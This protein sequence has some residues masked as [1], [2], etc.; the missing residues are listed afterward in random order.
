MTEKIRLRLGGIHAAKG[1]IKGALAQFDAVA[2]NP[3]SQLIGWANY[4]AGE[5]LIQNQQFGD[6]VKRLTIFRDNP[7]WQNVPGLSDRALVRLGYASSLAKGWDESRT[8]Y[9]RVVN[10][11]PNS[12]WGD[13]ARYGIGWALQQQKNFDGAANAYSQVVARSATDLAAKSQLQIGLCRM[14]QKRYLDAAN[15]FLVVPSTYDYPELRAAAILE[16]GKAFLELNQREQ[17]NRQFERVLREFPGTPWAD[18]AKE[19]LG[20]GK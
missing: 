6:A 16:A 14:E 10:N 2:S 7:N 8:A 12:P 15:A 13:E 17:A 1:N 19:R 18:A 4:R 20:D 3:K 5:V 9:E 11:F